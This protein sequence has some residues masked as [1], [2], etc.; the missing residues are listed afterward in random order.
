MYLPANTQC[1]YHQ[2]V[3]AHGYFSSA[4]HEIAHWCIAGK[5]RRELEDYG[6]WYCPDGRDA[7]QQSQFEQVE[8]K[9]Q[10]LEW[11][12]TIAANRRFQ[13]STDNLNGA[14]PDRAGFQRSVRQ[15]LV[16]YIQQG[17]PQRA[18]QFITALREQFDGPAL[19]IEWLDKA[20]PNE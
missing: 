1:A 10:S 14:E 3:F 20:Y 4:L 8:I 18:G 19:T 16:T 11:A 17:F 2:I 5:A 13:V 12:M 6:Y 15:Q 7:Q 9:P